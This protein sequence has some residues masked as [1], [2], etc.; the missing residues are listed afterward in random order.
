MASVRFTV[1]S[2]LFCLVLLISAFGQPCRAADLKVVYQDGE[3]QS[4]RLHQDPSA[5]RSIEFG[6]SS[7]LPSSS[8]GPGIPVTLYWHMADDADLYLNGRPLRTYEPSFRSRGDEAPLPAF[9]ASATVREGDVFT[10]GGRRG[11]SYGFMLIAVDDDSRVVFKSDAREWKVYEPGERPDWYLPHIAR[12]SPSHKVT[13]QPDP[14]YPQKTL[15][16][17]YGNIAQSIWDSP[18]Q[19]FAHMYGVVRFMH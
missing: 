16:S 9:T 10:V 4:I 2:A 12:K 14:W 8:S 7:A 5:I 15:N 17:Q 18:D 3:T 13:V 11:G 6:G 1:N 19:R